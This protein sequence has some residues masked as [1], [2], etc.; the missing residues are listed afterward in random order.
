MSVS[1]LKVNTRFKIYLTILTIFV[2]DIL[3]FYGFLGNYGYLRISIIESSIVIISI[4]WIV[5]VLHN[6]RLKDLFVLIILPFCLR[7]HFLILVELYLSM[8]T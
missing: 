7:F 2:L 4:Y 8:M 6:I 3:T 5:Q 1:I